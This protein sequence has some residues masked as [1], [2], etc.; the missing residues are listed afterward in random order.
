MT[1]RILD[2]HEGRTHIQCIH[3][4]ADRYNPYHVYLVTSATGAQI[5]RRPQAP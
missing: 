2:L 3:T 4:D 1:K 5:R